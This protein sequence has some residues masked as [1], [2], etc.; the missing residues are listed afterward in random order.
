MAA[1]RGA[2]TVT[3]SVLV[4]STFASAL[5]SSG[6]RMGVLK[7]VPKSIGTKP[8]PSRHTDSAALA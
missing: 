5:I 2:L 4:T 3:G 8:V 6:S 1:L 7:V